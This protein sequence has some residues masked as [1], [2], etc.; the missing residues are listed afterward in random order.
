MRLASASVLAAAAVRRLSACPRRPA[1]TCPDGRPR[2]QERIGVAAHERLVA[3]VLRFA[4]RRRAAADTR[5][6][7]P[8][9]APRSA[10]GDAT[11]STSLAWLDILR[12]T[13]LVAAGRRRA[14]PESRPPRRRGADP[15][16][17]RRRW[18]SRGRR[19]C[20]RSAL[21]G[22]REHESGRRSARSRR[23]R[24]ARR[25]SPPISRGSSTSGAAS[26]AAFSAASRRSRR[27]GSGRARDG[28]VARERRGV[29]LSPA[30]RARSGAS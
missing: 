4:R 15:R 22:S 17:P 16:V 20:R 23:L 13:T 28:A 3:R 6:C 11:R 12:D 27:A 25:V 18:A 21:N 14:R 29:E 1:C 24:I 30:P 9:T 5:A 7:A 2:S 8:S 19:C 26:A 10:P